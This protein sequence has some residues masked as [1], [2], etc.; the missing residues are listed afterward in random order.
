V[1]R[2]AADQRRSRCGGRD[3]ATDNVGADHNINDDAAGALLKLQC[4]RLLPWRLSPRCTLWIGMFLRAG[5]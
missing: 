5:V 3:A 4:R 2:T 1:D